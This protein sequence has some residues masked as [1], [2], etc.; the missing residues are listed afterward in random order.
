M[1][2]SNFFIDSNGPLTLD[3]IIKFIVY[4]TMMENMYYSYQVCNQ[5][6]TKYF[7]NISIIYM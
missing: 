2:T 7:G 4:E 6:W 3:C 1:E 5:T